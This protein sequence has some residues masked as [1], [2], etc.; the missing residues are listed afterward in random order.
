M[1]VSS[2]LPAPQ[3]ASNQNTTPA[4]WPN[5]WLGDEEAE[6]SRTAVVP[7]VLP[8]IPAIF[9]EFEIR[10]WAFDAEAFASGAGSAAFEPG[11][12][13]LDPMFAAFSLGPVGSDIGVREAR[14]AA[15]SAGEQ[16][17]SLRTHIADNTR[18]LKAVRKDDRTP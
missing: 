3:P 18:E 2:N 5:V 13:L 8:S 7:I 15:A 6:N 16:L 4:G 14:R 17:S 10:S 9:T 12:S 1:F 11:S